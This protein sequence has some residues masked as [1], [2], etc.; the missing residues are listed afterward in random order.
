M[1]I[2]WMN[3]VSLHKYTCICV[4]IIIVLVIVNKYPSILIVHYKENA[5]NHCSHITIYNMHTVLRKNRVHSFQDVH[6]LQQCIYKLVFLCYIHDGLQITIP[7]RHKSYIVILHG[8]YNV[9]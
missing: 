3:V 8:K 1:C 2:M 4:C 5:D 7:T 6:K 9:N